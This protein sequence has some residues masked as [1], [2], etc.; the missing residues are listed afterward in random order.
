MTRDGVG[1]GRRP[2]AAEPSEQLQVLLVKVAW[3]TRLQ[4]LLS[5]QG[6]GFGAIREAQQTLNI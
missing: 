2:T 1:A 3:I 4:K 5:I 6:G